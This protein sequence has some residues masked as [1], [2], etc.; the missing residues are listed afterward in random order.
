[1]RRMTAFGGF[2]LVLF[3]A[4]G[5]DL[6]A[7]GEKFFFFGRVIKH[8]Q[9]MAAPVPGVVLLYT[10]PASR[11]PAV[12]RATKLDELLKSVGHRV[13]AIAD[14]GEVSRVLKSGRYDLLLVDPADAAQAKQWA[15]PGVVVVPVLHR[16]TK[17]ELRAAQKTYARVLTADKTNDALVLVNDIVRSRPKARAT[18]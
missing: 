3:A 16:P 5:S 12:V 7:C 13:E 6:S 2:L 9:S 8:Q 15:P 11:L 1:M 4:G 14:A 17:P 18:P 10:N